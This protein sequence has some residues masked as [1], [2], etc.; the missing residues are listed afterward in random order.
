MGDILV[1]KS[2]RMESEAFSLVIERLIYIGYTNF[3]FLQIL[4]SFAI[5]TS[6]NIP[7]RFVDIQRKFVIS[8]MILHLSFEVFGLIQCMGI[9]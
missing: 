4:F 9:C 7:F 8:S 1:Y 6:E 2:P 3:I 5:Y